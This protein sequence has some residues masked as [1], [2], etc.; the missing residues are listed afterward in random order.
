LGNTTAN[1]VSI[2][3]AAMVTTSSGCILLAY[4]TASMKKPAVSPQ[5][6]GGTNH[7]LAMASG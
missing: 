7:Q 2:T 6:V 4:D 5:R 3:T 1:P